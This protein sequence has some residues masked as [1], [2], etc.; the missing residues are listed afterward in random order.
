MTRRTAQASHRCLCIQVTAWIRPAS[1]PMH[2]HTK[3]TPEYNY[4]LT[5]KQPLNFLQQ[6]PSHLLQNNI[7]TPIITTMPLPPPLIGLTHTCQ[8]TCLPAP[9]TH[10]THRNSH[11]GATQARKGWGKGRCASHLSV[12]LYVCVYVYMRVCV[13][14]CVRVCECVLEY[15]LASICPRTCG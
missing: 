5:P 6:R 3:H 15:G 4:T 12:L 11:W 9:P 14:V 10:E 8:V 7:P 1:T 13:S 2:A